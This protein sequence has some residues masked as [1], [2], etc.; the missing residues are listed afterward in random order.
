MATGNSGNVETIQSIRM[1]I[2]E[3]AYNALVVDGTITDGM[4]L[5]EINR[6]ILRKEEEGEVTSSDATI[7]PPFPDARNGDVITINGVKQSDTAEVGHGL[8]IGTFSGS[9]DF[10]S[11]SS[12]GSNV[13]GV[14]H[15]PYFSGS[16]SCSKDGDD[17]YML[18]TVGNYDQVIIGAPPTVANSGSYNMIAGVGTLLPKTF[19]GSLKLGGSRFQTPESESVG[20]VR[21]G[22]YTAKWIS[23]S[24]NNRAH[25]YAASINSMSIDNGTVFFTSSNFTTA[26]LNN[27]SQSSFVGSLCAM[28]GGLTANSGVSTRQYDGNLIFG[29]SSLDMELESSIAGIKWMCGG[30][31]SNSGSFRTNQYATGVILNLVA[32]VFFALGPS[33]SLNCISA[34]IESF[35][36]TTP[37][38]QG[39]FINRGGRMVSGSTQSSYFRYK[40]IKTIDGERD[41]RTKEAKK[42]TR[43]SNF[44]GTGQQITGDNPLK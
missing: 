22:S 19:S 27:L 37:G 31:Y 34:S 13:G 24:F 33:G 6:A 10:Y 9:A 39:G 30:K 17:G 44:I 38:V 11:T 23:G 42:Q 4:T 12:A 43:T 1:S 8:W 21:T 41:K 3:A 26:D 36:D 32:G 20:V 18:E 29:N 2:T 16:M 28:S 15:I 7:L 25:T 5:A 35:P 40:R 14:A